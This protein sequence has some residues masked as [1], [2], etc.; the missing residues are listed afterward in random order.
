MA[1]TT[2]QDWIEAT[3]RNLQGAYSE[4]RVLLSAPYTAGSGTLSFASANASIGIGAKLSVGINNF[5]VTAVN[6]TAQSAS[7]IGGQ[8][9]TTDANAATGAL[10]RINPQFTDFDIWT[11]IG[12]DLADLS[13][14]L[15]GLYSMQYTDFSIL[16][17]IVGYDLGTLAAQNL[18]SVYEVRYL[19]PG[20]YKD[21]PRLAQ[22]AWKENRQAVVS[23]IPSG[24]GLE[25]TSFGHMTPGRNMRVFWK[26]AFALPTTPFSA[27]STS[28]LPATCY[29][30]PPIGA[31]IAIM[32]G[33]EIMRNSP[34]QQEFRRATEVPAGAVTA[35][36]NGLKSLRQMRIDAEA[37]RL[38]DA[39]PPY[40]D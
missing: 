29:D 38:I 39:Y 15:N 28:L 2:G 20:N 21:S 3:R 36:A 17:T 13:S 19:T 14:P 8:D 16:S 31:A 9:G 18:I 22:Y 34:V 40:K 12:N 32:A 7:V 26:S 33:R 35:S 10:V 27:L 6:T 1:F 25:L 5:Y 37:A 24:M 11:A 23:D 4:Q 30:L